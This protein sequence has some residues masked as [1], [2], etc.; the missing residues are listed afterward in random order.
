[1]RDPYQIV[2]GIDAMK[3]RVREDFYKLLELYDCPVGVEIGVNRGH[4]S[5]HLLVTTGQNLTLY[6]VDSWD[7]KNGE[8]R[9]A[10]ARQRL[11][12]FGERNHIIVSTSV[13]AAKLFKDD[14]FDFVYIDA[15]HSYEAVKADLEAWWPKA[16]DK[17]LFSGHDYI[18]KRR[19]VD[20]VKAVDEFVALKKQE[21]FLTH[22]DGPTQ[23]DRLRSFYFFKNMAP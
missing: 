16:K 5:E 4:F 12:R 14:F 20:V 8:E 1:M 13:E 6:S 18:N 19:Q 21:L 11:S 22:E 10:E 7:S 15:D 2:D 9:L 17:A 23:E 3:I